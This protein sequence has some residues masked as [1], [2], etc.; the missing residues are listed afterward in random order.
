LQASIDNEATANVGPGFAAMFK[1]LGV[2]ATGIF[3]GVSENR[4][5]VEV[6]AVIDRHRHLHHRATVP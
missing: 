3:E 1:D 4:Q 6:S 5:T 2:G